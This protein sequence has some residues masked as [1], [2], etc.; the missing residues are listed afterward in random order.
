MNLPPKPNNLKQ[1]GIDWDKT[2]FETGGYPDYLPM[3]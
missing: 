1:V 2:I 3:V